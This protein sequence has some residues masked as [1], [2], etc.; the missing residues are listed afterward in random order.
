MKIGHSPKNFDYHPVFVAY[1][2]PFDAC[3][4]HIGDT[5]LQESGRG[6]DT[7]L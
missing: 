2:S 6:D 5:M 3:S 4:V 7:L 1:C